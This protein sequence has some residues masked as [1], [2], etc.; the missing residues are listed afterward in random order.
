MYITNNNPHDHKG[1][2]LVILNSQLFQH[3]FQSIF[4][5]NRSPH[6]VRVLLWLN[7]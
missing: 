4:F 2:G 7:A 5:H 6:M 3:N 1:G